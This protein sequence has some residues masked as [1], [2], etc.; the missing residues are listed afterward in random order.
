MSC[1]S[2]QGGTLMTRLGRST[3]GLSDKKI[4]SLFHAL[5]R[6]GDLLEDPSEDDIENWR[7]ETRE[8]FE[9]LELSASMLEKSERDL[10]LAKDE[11]YDGPTFHA[12]SHIA[13]R[14]RQE[15]VII[16]VKSAVADLSDAGAQASEYTLDEKG[17]P[18]YVWYASYGSNL[19]EGRFLTYIEG[20]SPEGT[21][22]SH[23]GARDKSKPIDS[24]PIRFEGRMHFAGTSYKWGKGG[25]A[26]MDKD[27]SGH[28]LGRAYLITFEQFK[29]VVAQE[30]GKT[31]GTLEIDGAEALN[32]GRSEVGIGLYNNLVHIGDY[33][34]SPVFTFTSSF[35]ASEAISN[36]QAVGGSKFGATNSPSNNYLRMIGRGLEE[37]FGMT[38]EEQADYLKG[39]LGAGQ[40]KRSE[41][42][43]ILST[44]P[45]V[46]EK[47]DSWSSKPNKN[48]SP[49][50]DS[51]DWAEWDRY[52]R[53]TRS[54]RGDYDWP[55]KRD[56]TP[57]WMDTPAS[58]Y[59]EEYDHDYRNFDEPIYDENDEIP[60]YDDYMYQP[61]KD[62]PM[63]F[64]DIKEKESYP[65]EFENFCDV[66]EKYGHSVYDCPHF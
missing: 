56:Y 24:T 53:D 35:S 43:D 34:G 26:F 58:N 7:L 2:T 61:S 37:S 18:K 22:S 49:I 27:T 60:L 19:S 12:L 1:R 32:N 20:G 29:D 25:I 38:I 50:R 13:A 57:W 55:P 9:T 47:Y 3:S 10:F 11:T 4:T 15:A 65:E 21:D 52:S 6:E 48:R 59:S 44:P 41:L 30:N 8:I 62:V 63:A 16:S 23:P 66:C 45:E 54:P 51:S 40:I 42:A 39:T 31:P 17:N 14:A 28:S 64:R 33:K 36:A 5:K 46:I